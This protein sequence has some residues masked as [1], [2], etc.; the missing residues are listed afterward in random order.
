MTKAASITLMGSKG[1]GKGGG[2]GGGAAFREDPNTLQSKVTAR[3]LEIIC[4]GGPWGIRGLVDGGK[5]IYIDRTPLINPDG[6]SNFGG[7]SWQFRNGVFDQEVISGFES[8]RS[9]FAVGVEVTVNTPATRRIVAPETSAVIVRV[10]LP[11]GLSFQ[12]TDPNN[13]VLAG[14]SVSSA[15]D[16]ST[17]GGPFIETRRADITGKTMSA[18][19]RGY[20]VDLQGNGPWDLRLRRLT[21]DSTASTLVNKT[22]WS[23]YTLVSGARLTYPGIA[24]MGYIVDAEE[25]GSNLPSRWVDCY[26]MYVEIPTNY[27]PE[28]RTYSG[29]WDGTF[30]VGWTDNPAWLVWWAITDADNALGE[31]IGDWARSLSKIELYQIAKYCD[32]LVDD[33]YGGKEPRFTFNSW[34]VDRQKGA[35][36]LRLICG[37]F[38]TMVFWGGGG[39]SFSQ[40]SPQPVSRVFTPANVIDGKFTYSETAMSA[41]HS[42]IEVSWHDPGDF[43]RAAIE[44]VEDAEMLQ[45]VGIKKSSISLIGC[46]SRGQARRAGEFAKYSEK[47]E[48]NAVAFAV[49]LGE[50]DIMPGQIV[51]IA[52]PDYAGVQFGGRLAGMD[53][54]ELILDREYEFRATDSYKILVAMSSGGMDTVEIVN[55][56]ATTDSIRIVRPFTGTP[57]P[58]AIWTII[59]SSLSPRPFRILSIAENGPLE[60]QVT[61]M[62]HAPE[63]Y[64]MIEKGIRL[65]PPPYTQIPTGSLP[66][67]ERLRADEYF[68]ASGSDVKSAFILSWIAPGDLRVNYYEVMINSPTDPDFQPYGLV[69]G[70]SMDVKDTIPGMYVFRVRSVSGLGIRSAWAEFSVL[71]SGLDLP[72]PDIQGLTSVFVS[73]RLNISWNSVND[74]RNYRYEVRIGDTWESGMLYADTQSTQVAV[75]RDGV[76]WVKAVFGNAQSKVAA[77]IEIEGSA[78]MREN[79]IARFDEGG[80]GWDGEKDGVIVVDGNKLMLASGLDFY[81]WD[82]FYSIT[83]FYMHGYSEGYGIYTMPESSEITLDSNSSCNI[84]IDIAGYAISRNEDFYSWSDFYAVQN[85]YGALGGGFAIEPQVL[86]RRDGV[87]GEWG[88]FIPGQYIGDGFRFRMHMST[89]NSETLVFLTKFKVAVDVPDRRV[90]YRN[91]TVPVDGLMIEFDPPFN[92]TPTVI[93]TILDATGQ[94]DVF[95]EDGLIDRF[96]MLVR[97]INKQQETI[98]KQLN[99]LV[100]GY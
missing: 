24:L 16:V 66:P 58:G 54:Q 47:F 39:I 56:V 7:F 37:S 34:M 3:L 52:D 78:G 65:E 31:A 79:V 27:D 42:V 48:S 95:L 8:V 77:G 19:E 75:S 22:S 38:R 12:N 92:A 33:G 15:I 45:K 71:L 36:Y 60:Y 46:T 5:S 30:K 29:L 32:E 93:A 88:K 87:W 55:P 62:Q 57:V 74:I 68:Y 43:C 44:V 69:T 81:S 73:N 53:G 82:D 70:V 10:Q 67:P 17:A 21:A 49:G 100:E 83:D 50:C 96:G 76:Y 40:D 89:E 85:F 91:V 86:V 23:G 61:A 35:D 80:R 51:G 64:D 13:P 59:S 84:E 6:S 18:F 97:V 90:H 72:L 94:E 28:K 1:G 26:G 63:K 11:N 20:W 4:C 41:R 2:G 99:I 9:E 25:F 14:T 98:E